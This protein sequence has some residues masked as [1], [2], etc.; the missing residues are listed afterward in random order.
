MSREQVS[1]VAKP[2]HRTALQMKE[3]PRGLGRTQGTIRAGF[4]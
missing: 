3:A 4:T 2:A 1:F